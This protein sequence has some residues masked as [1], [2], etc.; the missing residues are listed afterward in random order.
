MNSPHILLTRKL[1]RLIVIAL[2]KEK[3]RNREASTF[4]KSS[5]FCSSWFLRET[6]RPLS[7]EKLNKHWNCW[8]SHCPCLLLGTRSQQTQS[9]RCHP[10][11][12]SHANS[13]LS[14]CMLLACAYQSARQR[15]MGMARN[16]AKALDDYLAKEGYLE[17]LFSNKRS[18]TINPVYLPQT[19]PEQHKE[20]ANQKKTVSHNSCPRFYPATWEEH[21]KNNYNPDHVLLWKTCT[22]K[23]F[24]NVYTL[25]LGWY[26][27]KRHLLEQ[28]LKPTHAEKQSPELWQVCWQVKSSLL[29][30][31]MQKKL[32]FSF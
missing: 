29:W 23:K 18:G 9:H 11:S 3:R 12:V 24:I 25:D 1:C 4:F 21:P 8:L 16:L 5:M 2:W 32:C 10:A 27:I 20:Y 22:G 19:T 6:A 31:E 28:L 7:C 26:V 13:T 15:N 14:K 17:D 30:L